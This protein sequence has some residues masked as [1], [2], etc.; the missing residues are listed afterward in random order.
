MGDNSKETLQNLLKELYARFRLAYYHSEGIHKQLCLLLAISHITEKQT[1]TRPRFDELIVQAFSLTLGEVAR[2]F[3]KQ[4]PADFR[5][6]LSDV[7]QARN[8]LAHR[9]WFERVPQLM[10]AE[11][12]MSLLQELDGYSTLFQSTNE[13]FMQMFQQRFVEIGV[14]DEALTTTLSKV[15]GGDLLKPLPSR[16]MIR[17][18]EKKLKGK[19]GIAK[20]WEIEV[21]EN[22][23]TLVFESIEGDLW[24]L[25]DVGLGLTESRQKEAFWVEQ[26]LISEYLPAVIEPR[27]KGA[28]E[29]NYKFDLN[30]AAK[31]LVRP[32]QTKGTFV[33]T[34]KLGK[35][36]A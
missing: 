1:M 22:M 10:T 25:S 17:R 32:G 34:I 4:L 8:F 5:Q 6:A 19:V 13:R 26:K 27:P 35:E 24:Q 33:W 14:T 20:V 15:L 31:L 30:K 16:E 11:G 12:V 9:F 29:W 36:S 21:S 23:S 18:M 3:E 28:T 2:E 7:V